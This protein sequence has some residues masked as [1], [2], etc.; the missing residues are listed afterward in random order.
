MSYVFFPIV[1][2]FLIYEIIN[3]PK[4]RACFWLYNIV[5]AYT[6]FF[7]L[8]LWLL[9]SVYLVHALL[10]IWCIDSVAFLGGYWMGQVPLWKSVSP[11]KTVEGAACAIIIGVLWPFMPL[12]GGIVA[13][14]SV[15]GDLVESRLKRLAGCKDSGNFLP[16]HGGLLDRIDSVTAGLPLYFFFL[17]FGVN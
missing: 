1:W 11:N 2:A 4:R 6:W 13:L 5:L 10:F 15:Y 3:H 9:G 16:G 12:K 8:K 7:A 14:A 17:L